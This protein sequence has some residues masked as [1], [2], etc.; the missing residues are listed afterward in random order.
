MGMAADSVF[1]PLATVAGREPSGPREIA[2]DEAT[3][4]K[5]GFVVGSSIGVAAATPLESFRVVGIF[6]S[7]A[8]SRSSPIQMIVLDLPVAQRL[9]DKQG[10][11]DVID[12]RG[13]EG[14][15]SDESS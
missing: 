7:A 6:G 12:V 3:A 8:S 2:L 11:Y 15:T 9:F 5:N 10:L 4:T 1:N 13:R 14:V